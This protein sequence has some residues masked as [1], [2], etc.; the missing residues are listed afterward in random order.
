M[1][2][3][4]TLNCATGK[5]SIR[6]TISSVCLDYPDSPKLLRKRL[7]AWTYPALTFPE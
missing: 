2:R 4:I 5:R 7:S 3:R 1:S 6:K